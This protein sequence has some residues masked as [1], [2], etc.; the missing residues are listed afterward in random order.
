[1]EVFLV[2]L[3]GVVLVGHWDFSTQP[4]LARYEQY[5]RSLTSSPKQSLPPG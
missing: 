5:T 2:T 3:L 4:P 1:M